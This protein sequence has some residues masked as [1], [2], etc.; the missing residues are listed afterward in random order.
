MKH[1]HTPLGVNVFGCELQ[2]S[3]PPTRN[4]T[5]QQQLKII[6]F[7]PFS[8]FFFYFLLLFAKIQTE[9]NFKSTTCQTNFRHAEPMKRKRE[10]LFRPAVISGYHTAL[11]LKSFPLSGSRIDPHFRYIDHRSVQSHSARHL[12][13]I[14]SVVQW[15]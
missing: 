14:V 4:T 9:I 10:S 15:L 11:C 3:S 6:C 13:E 1:S 12:C 7:I 8:F 2:A 5:T